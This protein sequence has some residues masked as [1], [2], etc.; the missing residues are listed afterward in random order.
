MGVTET[1][2]GGSI[3][4]GTNCK[5]AIELAQSVYEKDKDARAALKP[6]V[7][8]YKNDDGFKEKFSKLT[9]MTQQDAFT[10]FA[11]KCPEEAKTFATIVDNV[12][13][14]LGLGDAAPPFPPA[15]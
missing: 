11:E 9:E 15:K 13:D 10:M 7:E 14:E 2:F 8:K 4:T 12:G 1:T 6:D 5:D 3:F